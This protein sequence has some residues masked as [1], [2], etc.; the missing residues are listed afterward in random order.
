MEV[1]FSPSPYWLENCIN[2]SVFPGLYTIIKHYPSILF[3]LG[4]TTDYSDNA[5][6]S[7]NGKISSLFGLSIIDSN[8]F[9]EH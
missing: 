8:Y 2:G 3:T 7:P 4:S 6:T 1:D 9:F 5:E